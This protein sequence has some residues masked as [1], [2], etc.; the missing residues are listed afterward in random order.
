MIKSEAKE[1]EI[2]KIGREIAA[3][4]SQNKIVTVQTAKM[5]GEALN[6]PIFVDSPIKQAQLSCSQDLLVVVTELHSLI[7]VDLRSGHQISIKSREH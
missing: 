5:E 3:L 6:D 7:V 4:I 1:L 2:V